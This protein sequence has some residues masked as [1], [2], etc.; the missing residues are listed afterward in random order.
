MSPKIAH[1]PKIASAG[2][3]CHRIETVVM[4]NSDTPKITAVH[5][6]LHVALNTKSKTSHLH[7][8]GD[9]YSPVCVCDPE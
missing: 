2:R 5:S 3:A 8:L 7:M 1:Q 9:Q 6:D 4:E